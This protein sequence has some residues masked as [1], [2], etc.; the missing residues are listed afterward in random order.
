MTGFE[1]TWTRSTQE[2]RDGEPRSWVAVDTRQDPPVAVYSVQRD[3]DAPRGRQWTLRAWIGADHPREKQTRTG[4][5]TMTLAQEGALSTRC[6]LCFRLRPFAATEA[7][8]STGGWRCRDHED[9]AAAT[10]ARA[11]EARRTHLGIRNTDMED[12]SVRDTEDGPELLFTT[13]GTGN[14]QVVQCTER[15]LARLRAVLARRF[16]NRTLAEMREL[17]RPS[18]H[19]NTGEPS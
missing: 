11:D 9:C 14:R 13:A 6:H 12:I 16:L 7:S 8:G 3:R 15:D 1:L 4:F 17:T 10:Q 18:E 19:E 2:Y 5:A